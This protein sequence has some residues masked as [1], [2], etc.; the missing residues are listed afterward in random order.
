MTP[1]APASLPAFRFSH[2][3]KAASLALPLQALQDLFAV[4]AVVV[5][6]E[7]VEGFGDDVGVVESLNAGFAGGVETEPVHEMDVFRLEIGSVRPDAEGIC[8][9]LGLHH[10]KHELALGFG[11]GFPGAT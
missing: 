4:G 6:D 3:R 2:A 9:H 5:A 11:H 8:R 7:A 1:A 10:L